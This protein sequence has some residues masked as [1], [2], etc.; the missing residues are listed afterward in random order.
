[1][2]GAGLAVAL[3]SSFFSFPTHAGFL[4][5]LGELGL[6]PDS[7]SG[8]SS[9]AI[10]AS[11]YASGID[12]GQVREV[13]TSKAVTQC[14]GESWRGLRM[15]LTVLG[16]GGS[17]GA[18]KGERLLAMLREVVGAGRIEDCPAAR[19]AV[20]LTNLTSGRGEL[21]RTGPL[22]ET[23]VASC[24]IPGFFA[25]REVHG[26]WCW[27]GGLTSSV[28]V[29]AW[30]GDESTDVIIAHEILNTI[31]I[32][33]ADKPER[34]NLYQALAVAHQ[35]AG[36][37]VLRLKLRLA[38]H[39]GQRVIV[40]RTVTPRP[41]IGLPFGMPGRPWPEQA[42]ELYELGRQSALEQHEALRGV[43]ALPQAT[44]SGKDQRALR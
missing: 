19:L 22:A 37:E 39:T 43:I 3:G 21:A 8:A 23:V 7:V 10:A 29:E 14:F 26:G 41:R 4:A 27:D 15:L 32:D 44:S 11:F 6:R 25:L 28:P 2:S 30:L 9:G 40:C 17:T 24:G 36:D 34:L 35:T 1:V 5:G 31:Q 12:A 16:R 18:V 38:E 13:V 33:M 20:G 42:A